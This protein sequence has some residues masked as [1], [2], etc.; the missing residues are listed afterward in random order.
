MSNLLPLPGIPTY[1]IAVLEP[2]SI[3]ETERAVSALKAGTVVLFNLSGV[4]PEQAQRYVD[5]ASGSTCAISGHQIKVG[6]DIFLY[7]PPTVEIQTEI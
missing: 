1:A 5:F 3:A 7:T 4:E 2:Q 6:Q